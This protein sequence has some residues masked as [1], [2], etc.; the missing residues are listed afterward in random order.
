MS[1]TQTT[2]F[3]PSYHLRTPQ[4]VLTWL[5]WFVPSLKRLFRNFYRTS[6]KGTNKD[7]S[8]SFPSKYLLQKRIVIM[9][10]TQ[11][12]NWMFTVHN[13]DTRR[14][15]KYGT[16]P[17]KH[18]CMF[19]HRDSHI[20]LKYIWKIRCQ[21]LP[22]WWTKIKKRWEPKTVTV[23]WHST[24]FHAS[25]NSTWYNLP[26]RQF[27]SVSWEPQRHSQLKN[28]TKKICKG[29]VELKKPTELFMQVCL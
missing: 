2:V 20:T 1:P 21:Q 13:R 18:D 19:R 3:F 26:R 12:D 7:G 17:V 16:S 28:K 4:R 6:L 27:G 5:L 10:E 25:R 24:R 11:N 14:P 29:S 15:N 9:L 22:V 8:H 23:L